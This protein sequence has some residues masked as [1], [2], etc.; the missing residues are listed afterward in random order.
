[1]SRREAGVVLRRRSTGADGDRPIGAGP[2]PVVRVVLYDVVG[3]HAVV[4]HRH[5]QLKSQRNTPFLYFS[6]KGNSIT[7]SGG[8]KLVVW[9]GS[10]Q[11]LLFSNLCFVFKPDCNMTS[12]E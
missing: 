2:F 5:Q 9:G 1:M 4:K 11:V 3:F 8:I 10:L 7:Q 6:F 12:R